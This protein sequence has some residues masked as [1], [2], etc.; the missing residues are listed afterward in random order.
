[1]RSEGGAWAALTG[2]S[3]L[4]LLCFALFVAVIGGAV[5]G[6]VTLLMLP[7]A[8]WI[9]RSMRRVHSRWAHATVYL[10]LGSIIGGLVGSLRGVLSIGGD[11]AVTV[12]D[13]GLPAALTGTAAAAGWVIAIH[14]ALRTDRKLATVR[15]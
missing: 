3:I 12:L 14:R 8:G 13:I 1:M 6:V 9:G 7:L 10:L 2:G 11:G 4:L 5:A 15:S